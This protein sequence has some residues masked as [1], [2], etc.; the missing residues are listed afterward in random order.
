VITNFKAINKAL[1]TMFV[2][3]GSISLTY[4]FLAWLFLSVYDRLG[5]EKTLIILGIGVINYGIRR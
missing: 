4:S 5:F 1:T 2:K 3:F